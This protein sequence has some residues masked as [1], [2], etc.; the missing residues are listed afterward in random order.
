MTNNEPS[1]L[2]RMGQVYR[3]A[4]PE[5]PGEQRVDGLPNFYWH[6][7][8]EGTKMAKLER[9]ISR[10][11][12]VPAGTGERV[13]AILLRSTPWK[14]GAERVP[15]HDEFNADTGTVTYF[16]DN[17]IDERTGQPKAEDPDDVLGNGYLREHF[18]EAMSGDSDRRD[19]GGPV[20]LFTGVP[21]EG[22]PKGNVRFDG[23]GVVTEVSLVNQSATAGG[24][25]YFNYAFTVQLFN[26]EA[27]D[28][29]ID[30]R[31]ISGRRLAASPSD[32]RRLEP[33]AWKQWCDEG[34]VAQEQLWL[35]DVP[36]R[37]LSMPSSDG[38]AAASRV[39]R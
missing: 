29:S 38:S 15:W 21:F 5:R 20:L 9:G 35:S 31:W 34:L 4:R 12:V 7:H 25:E 28:W 37:T 23:L 14:A 10:L 33:L 17:K 1:R 6:T 11:P 3:Y 13:P 2:V 18:R 32:Y 26:L 19:R 22:R 36:V 8:T 27:D 30:W 16:G 39:K 24:A